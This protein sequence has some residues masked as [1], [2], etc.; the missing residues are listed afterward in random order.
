MHVGTLLGELGE[1][2][3]VYNQITCAGEQAALQRE[4]EARTRIQAAEMQIEVARKKFVTVKGDQ[5][6]CNRARRYGGQRR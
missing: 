4:E 3:G 5:N 6:E 2:V 1:E